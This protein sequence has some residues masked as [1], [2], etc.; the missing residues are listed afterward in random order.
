MINIMNSYFLRLFSGLALVA[1]ILAF[2]GVTTAADAA[3]K[4]IAFLV[5]DVNS[6]KSLG[7]HEDREPRHP[8]SLTKMMTLYMMFDAIEDGRYSMKSRLHVSANAAGK[9]AS[10]LYVKAGSTIS[11]EDAIDALIVKSA[12]DVATVVAENLGG[13][14]SGFAKNMTLAARQIGMTNTTFKNASG[15]HHHDQVTTAYDMYLLA[16]ALQDRFPSLYKRFSKTSFV[17][18]GRRI[19]GHNPFTGRLA[20]VNGIKTGY[21]RASG[22]NLVTN[23]QRDGRHLVAVVVGASTSSQRNQLM[24]NI[25][26]KATRSATAGTRRTARMD[27]D[28]N[29]V[30]GRT[31]RITS[32][33]PSASARP[34]SRTSLMETINADVQVA[35][36]GGTVDR[37]HKQSTAIRSRGAEVSAHKKPLLFSILPEVFYAKDS[38]TLA[39]MADDYAKTIRQAEI[40]DHERRKL[41]AFDKWKFDV[42]GYD[43]AIAALDRVSISSKAFEPVSCLEEKTC[44]MTGVIQTSGGHYRVENTELFA[45]II[46]GQ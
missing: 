15:L 11:V 43:Q 22:F 39:L 29:T 21:T 2:I 37:A 45:M 42:A 3:P 30:R 34:Q 18:N 44:F 40:Q 12:N 5:M 13:T 24:S 6:G 19:G 8:A 33:L 26:T 1:A 32:T 41:Q 4:K 7:F 31:I 25:L 10:K 20:G 46:S 17:Y 23:L 28:I 9:P 35:S 16:L 36:F 14:E 38:A 27:T